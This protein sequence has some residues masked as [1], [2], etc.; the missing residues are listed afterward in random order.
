M[1]KIKYT[2]ITEIDKLNETQISIGNYAGTRNYF[3][4]QNEY[5]DRDNCTV[6]IEP[7]E[8]L[9]DCIWITI[10]NWQ[11]SQMIVKK[12]QIIRSQDGY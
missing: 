5:L 4:V 1:T 2:K 10:P 9:G 3:F 6:D 8:P 7:G 12:S 11:K